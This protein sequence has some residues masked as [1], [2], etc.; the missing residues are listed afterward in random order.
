MH[1]RKSSGLVVADNIINV[2]KKIQGITHIDVY[3]NSWVNPYEYRET[4][5]CLHVSNSEDN[6]DMND[7]VLFFGEHKSSD[8]VIVYS[9]HQKDSRP[10]MRD[11]KYE[12]GVH[13]KSGEYGKVVSHLISEIMRVFPHP[14]TSNVEDILKLNHLI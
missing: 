1:I 2:L 13:F 3:K 5:Y 6:S 10:F 9:L 14:G 8:D 11:F 4:G 7:L 12:N